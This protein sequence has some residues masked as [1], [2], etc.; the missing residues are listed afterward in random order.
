MM[1][2]FIDFILQFKLDFILCCVFVFIDFLTGIIYALLNGEYSSH[3]CRKGFEK[4]IGYL[5]VKICLLFIS[6]ILPQLKASF[7]VFAF[8]VIFIEFTSIIENV[9]PYLPEKIQDF[10]NKIL[11]NVNKEGDDNG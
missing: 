1:K 9:K 3:K 7:H 4:I 5:I 6:Y 11:K 8:S 2:D 10:L